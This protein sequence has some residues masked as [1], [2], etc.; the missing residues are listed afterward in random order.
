VPWIEVGA[1][2]T[3]AVAL[4]VAAFV[5]DHRAFAGSMLRA[6]VL[7][8]AVTAAFLLDEPAAQAV[9]A[10][11]RSPR[12]WF[13]ARVVG[14]VPVLVTPCAVLWLWAARH[15]TERSGATA[16]AAVALALVVFA[17]A[18][19][20]RHYGRATPGDVIAG[21][22]GVAIIALVLFQPEVGGVPMLP[23]TP[24]GHPAGTLGLWTAVGVASI[25][26]AAVVAVRPHRP[27]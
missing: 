8:W 12:W 11:P 14:L 22:T 9:D 23:G 7:L 10:A 21:V 16:M 18:A 2:S 25:G 1:A 4:V 17:M 27:E 24:S 5:L 19:V 20:V 13:C 6:G 3:P 15:E 26:I